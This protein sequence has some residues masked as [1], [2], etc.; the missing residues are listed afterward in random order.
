VRHE[1]LCRT[2]QN[3]NLV[4][5]H[6][7]SFSS[8][9]WLFASLI[10]LNYFAFARHWCSPYLGTVIAVSLAETRT[11]SSPM[12]I[13]SPLNGGGGLAGKSGRKTANACDISARKTSVDS[14]PHFMFVAKNTF[15]ESLSSWCHRAGNFHDDTLP[16]TLSC[17]HVL[18][19]HLSTYPG[20]LCR[21]PTADGF[22]L[23]EEPLSVIASCSC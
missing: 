7:F 6:V 16:P 12:T 11:K 15:T 22:G 23:P 4:T 13:V 10:G 1:L 5:T 14:A 20:S 17:A 8:P 3:F 18:P 2:E 9:F 19:G 21:Q